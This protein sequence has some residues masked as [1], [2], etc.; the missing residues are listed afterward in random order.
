MKWFA[1]KYK[2]WIHQV[3]CDILSW[4]KLNLDD[5]LTTVLQPRVLW[6]EFALLMFARMY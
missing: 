6:D 2:D 1:V 4:K 5:Y 3:G